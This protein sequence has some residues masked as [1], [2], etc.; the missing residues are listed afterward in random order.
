MPIARREFFRL[1]G[2]AGAL[3]LFPSKV[4]ACVVFPD[5]KPRM[6]ASLKKQIGDNAFQAA[7]R[8]GLTDVFAEEEAIAGEHAELLWD[9]ARYHSFHKRT[10]GPALEVPLLVPDEGKTGV[11]WWYAGDLIIPVQN[12]R[13]DPLHIQMLAWRSWHGTPSQMG[14]E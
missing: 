11:V 6:L 8:H 14:K 4:V 9:E 10:E 7:C 5:A 12:G 1:T 3:A 13:I 2:V